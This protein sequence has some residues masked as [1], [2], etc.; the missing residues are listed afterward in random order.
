MINKCN[1]TLK[2]KYLESDQGTALKAVC[3]S[4][5]MINLACLRHLCVSLHYVPETYYIVELVKALTKEQLINIK[6]RMIEQYNTM[7]NGDEKHDNKIMNDINRS[8]KKVGLTFTKDDIMII[9]DLKWK[10]VSMFH[11]VKTRM[12][13][14]TNAL[15]STHGHINKSTPRRNNFYGA[16]YRIVKHVMDKSQRIE[17][18]IKI[19]YARAKR[20]TMKALKQKSESRMRD[21]IRFYHSSIDKCECGENYLI[22]SILEIDVPCSHRIFLGAIFPPLHPQHMVIKPH[23][24]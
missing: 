24:R 7:L 21:E 1:I 16:L 8:L 14:T 19:N 13:S 5:E 20:V 2:G 4:F 18:C 15:E 17:E 10:S 9:D 6:L 3:N 23:K 22:S 11:R 12:P